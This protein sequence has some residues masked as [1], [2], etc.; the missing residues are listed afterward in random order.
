[1]GT[2]DDLIAT[3]GSGTVY[4]RLTPIGSEDALNQAAVFGAVPKDYLDFIAQ[5]GFGE[6]GDSCFMLYGGPMEP[7]EVFGTD[8]RLPPG[9]LLLGDDFNGFHV[10]FDT[11]DWSVVEIDSADRGTTFIGT[12]F[13]DFIRSKIASI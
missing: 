5:V 7:E 1:M 4:D 10:A 6:L 9:L 11:K 8:G 13:E 2:Y 12:N 3:K